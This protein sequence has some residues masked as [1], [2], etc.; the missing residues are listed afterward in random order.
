MTAA[1]LNIVPFVSVDHMMKLVLAIGV[2]RFL[3]ELAAYIEEDFR[4]WEL[5]DK[6][7]RIASPQ[8][9]RRDR[10]DADQ[11][12]PALRLQICQRPSEEHAR[13]PPDGDRFRRARRCRQRLSDAAVGDDHPDGAAHGGDC[14]RWPRSIW[15]RRA[16]A[17]MAIIGN[18]AQSEFQA[19]AFKALLGIDR[20]RLYDIDPAA[21]RNAARTTSPAS[22]STSRSAPRAQEAVEGAEIITTV[23]ADKQIR[24]DPDR[25]HGGLGRA[26]QRGR[27]RLPRQDRTAP[28][29]PA[30]LRASSSNIRRRRASRAR[31]SSSPPIIRSP[32]CGR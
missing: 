9:G 13:R 7:P 27:R 32:N 19:I 1:N 18:G 31:S 10:A 2:E 12:R 4:R 8:H 11:R 25:Q 17:R 28:R 29:H 21:T 23:T 30:A 3:T 26:H 16:P 22:A 24:D 5:F 14:R 20:L 6:T 15:R